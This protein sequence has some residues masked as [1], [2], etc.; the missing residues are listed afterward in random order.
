MRTIVSSAGPKTLVA[1]FN[2][3]ATS[4]IIAR[5]IDGQVSDRGS[6]AMAGSKVTNKTEADRIIRKWAVALRNHLGERGETTTAER[7]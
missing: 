6:F 2:D 1:E 3:S 4:D 5:V 7:G